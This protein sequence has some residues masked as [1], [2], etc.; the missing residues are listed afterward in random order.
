[1]CSD[2]RGPLIR[3]GMIEDARPSALSPCL[4]SSP[5]EPTLR[6]LSALARRQFA[7][8]SAFFLRCGFVISAVSSRPCPPRQRQRVNCRHLLW[9]RERRS[10]RSGRRI[11]TVQAAFMPQR[12]SATRAFGADR[13]GSPKR[14]SIPDQA[15]H[16]CLRGRLGRGGVASDGL[17]Y[18]SVPR[19]GR[20]S[21]ERPDYGRNPDSGGPHA[22]GTGSQTD[23]LGIPTT[24]VEVITI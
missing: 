9:D 2:T 10:L 14:K 8:L 15:T 4:G 19:P 13:P 12:S 20:C 3:R 21:G 5:P 11:A 6:V 16:P 1:M 24:A 22:R 23:I 17:L 7:S 18:G